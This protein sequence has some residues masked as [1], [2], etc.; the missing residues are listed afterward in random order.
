MIDEVKNNRQIKSLA[1][2]PYQLEIKEADPESI[3]VITDFAKKTG[4]FAALS[5]TDIKVLA[6]TYELEKR[7]VGVEH[8]KSDPI[9][10]KT[11]YTSN[12]NNANS[13]IAGFY[14]PENTSKSL[15]P[16]EN[17]DEIVDDYESSDE[18]VESDTSEEDASVNDEELSKK[19]GSLGFNTIQN[20]VKHCICYEEKMY[21]CVSFFFR[22][23]MISF[24]PL[25]KRKVLRAIMMMVVIAMRVKMEVP[26]MIQK[27][28]R[29]QV[30]MKVGLR[31]AILPM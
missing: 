4:D 21:L 19:F 11:V 9:V 13:H 3:K 17:E 30:M 8:L 15:S 6:L 31:L 29:D 7:F 5:V 22:K 14:N 20:S 23:L 16:F 12:K 1:V 26:K 10:S 27:L 24:N 25:R 2:L 18:E 28:R